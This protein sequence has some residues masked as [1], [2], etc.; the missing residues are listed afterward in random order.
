MV[1]QTDDKNICI[2]PFV[3]NLFQHTELIKFCSTDIILNSFIINSG[4][5]MSYVST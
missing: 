1:E 2:I 5:Y 3:E 4:K